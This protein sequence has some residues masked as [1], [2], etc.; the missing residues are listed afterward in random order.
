MSGRFRLNICEYYRAEICALQTETEFA[1]LDINFFPARCGRPPITLAELNQESSDSPDDDYSVCIGSACLVHLANSTEAASRVQIHHLRQCF[2]LFIPE[3][4]VDHFTLSGAYLC[5]PGWLVD[6]RL[7]MSEL[8]EDQAIIREIFHDSASKIVLLDTGVDPNSA[9]LLREFAEYL[10]LPCEVLA[11]GLDHFRLRIHNLLLQK[12]I[13]VLQQ[14]RG[15]AE[16]ADQQ[17]PAD[18]A[19]ALDLLSELP[20]SETE[21]I[22]IDRIEYVL[23]ML[24]APIEYHLLIITDGKADKLRSYQPTKT[25]EEV[26]E[27]L[28]MI[29]RSY[30][31]TEDGAGFFFKVGESDNTIAVIELTACTQR[32]SVQHYLNLCLSIRG[33]VALA[34]MNARIFSDNLETTRKLQEAL[35]N[36]KVLRGLIPICSYCKQIRTDKGAWQAVEEYVSS[37]SEAVFSHGICPQCIEKHFPKFV[38]KTTD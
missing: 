28:M 35:E 15:R 8:G 1:N 36:V 29:D 23:S 4:L 5:T 6:W 30:G 37:H 20:R 11:V 7:Q 2:S 32:E 25:K 10:D 14:Q 3:V 16:T 38:K 21:E 27:R 19:M 34:I 17:N 31:V 13:Q 24:F 9:S 18:Y 26:I 12:Q 33:I 22:V